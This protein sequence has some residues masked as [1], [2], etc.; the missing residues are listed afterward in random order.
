MPAAY[1][2]DHQGFDSISNK[3]Y[4]TNPRTTKVRKM[5]AIYDILLP[6]KKELSVKDKDNN[7]MTNNAAKINERS[8]LSGNAEYLIYEKMEAIT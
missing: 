5:N 4:S 8:M 2:I 1:V 3:K 6:L 7:A